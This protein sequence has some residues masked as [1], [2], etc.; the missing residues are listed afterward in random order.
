MPTTG[1]P[2]VSANTVGLYVHLPFCRHKCGY[3]H[4]F[5]LPDREDL[6][7]SLARGLALEWA[8]VRPYFSNKTLVSIYFGGG[9]PSLYGPERLGAF[10][11]LLADEATLAPE[12]EIT[13]E[14]NPEDVSEALIRDYASVGVNR[15]SM[16]IQ[17]LDDD[18]LQLLTRTHSSADAVR[19]VQAV[20]YAGI[21]N[22]SVDLMYDIPQQNLATWETTLARACTLPIQHLSLYNLTI[23]P[24][25]AFYKRREQLE[26]KRPPDDESRRM[27]ESAI[28][29]FEAAGLMQYEISAFARRG[30]EAIHNSGYWTGRPFWGLGPSAYSYWEGARLRNVAH[31]GK[32]LKKLEA[33]EPAHDFVEKLEPAAHTREMLVIA[34]RLVSGVDLP[35]FE[36]QHG[37]LDTE[38]LAS[39]KALASDGLVVHEGSQLLLT[40]RGRLFYDSVATELV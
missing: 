28:A 8:R 16:G 22:I 1:D 3:C 38:T 35:N 34:L 37:V 15:V 19:A 26:A 11:S 40:P 21:D 5:V 12:C 2:H 23:E 25:T 24:H 20:G 14:A 31:L 29:H 32:Y 36:A 7:D 10:L 13:L 39:L 17:S 27:Y 33:G 6:K 18:L 9:T 4:F 30:H